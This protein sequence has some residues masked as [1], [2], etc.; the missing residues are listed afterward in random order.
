MPL[1]RSLYT[2]RVCARASGGA[3]RG[4]GGGVREGSRCKP[5]RHRTLHEVPTL[6][7][8][9][10]NQVGEILDIKD[11]KA[12]AAIFA[13]FPLNFE[14]PDKDDAFIA[15]YLVEGHLE[16]GARE[17]SDRNGGA[18]EVVRLLMRGKEHQKWKK[19]CEELLSV[20]KGLMV[21]AMVQGT[22]L[23]LGLTCCQPTAVDPASYMRFIT[24]VWQR[25]G[26]V[27]V[28][29]CVRARVRACVR[30][31]RCH[32]EY[33]HV[34][35]RTEPACSPTHDGGV[36][37][38][39]AGLEVISLYVEKLEAA[40]HTA[41]LCEIYAAA[42]KSQ[43]IPGFSL[44][45]LAKTTRGWHVE[46]TDGMWR[47]S[48]RLSVEDEEMKKFYRLKGWLCGATLRL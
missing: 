39:C 35:R 40:N 11:P 43:P 48:G 26:H 16:A 1:A 24:S 10:G 13:K 42:N 44:E 12:A 36:W 37:V 9:G 5:T 3:E 4:G 22:T 2:S 20:G 8:R 23:L 47:V 41:I 45:L 33:R 31:C 29:A 25:A 15:D 46:Q 27:C 6:N 17:C 18:G 38:G 7:P 19:G 32:A 21:M 28:R 30:A 14:A 34:P